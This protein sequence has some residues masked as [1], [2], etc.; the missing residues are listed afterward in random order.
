M[1]IDSNVMSNDV[2]I[3]AID[4]T[5]RKNF[6]SEILK[7]SEFKSRLLDIEHSLKNPNLR[8]RVKNALEKA[9]LDLA[10]HIKELENSTSLNFYI[11]ESA[12]LLDKYND[13]LKTPVKMSFTGKSNVNNK[14]K[15]DIINKYIKIAQKYINIDY[16]QIKTVISCQNCGNSKEFDI[17]D[18]NIFICALCFTQQSIV[19]HTSS[20]NDVNRVNI[21]SKYT[22]DRKIHFR[23][24]INQYQGKQNCTIP[25]KIYTDLEDQF[26]HH[27]LL[28]HNASNKFEKFKNITKNHILI[29]L[30]ELG[31]SNQYENVHLIHYVLT[32]IKPDDI[33]YLEDQLL[34]D[35]D[36]LT[37]T[38]DKLFKNIARKNFINTQYVLYQ[39][40]KRHKHVCKK[41]DFVILKTLDRKNFH[42]EI[43]KVLFEHQGWN[44]TL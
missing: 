24:C 21:S 44:Q 18:N 32:G 10:Y 28:V 4:K 15:N 14:E 38:Y 34:T 40:L 27:H 26:E 31:Y 43:I 13:I 2:D 9:R 7:I 33:S 20:Y 6:E 8:D 25:S 37:E 35:F 29:F 23:D 42:D 22:Y 19:K 39:L 17:I 11:F 16:K 3:L 41:E 30:K 1:I 12:E 36:I 5:I